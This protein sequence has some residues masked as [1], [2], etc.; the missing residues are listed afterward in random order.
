MGRVA[1]G[2]WSI[3]AAAEAAAVDGDHACSLE[4]ED[5]LEENVQSDPAV[6]RLR[7]SRC[8]MERAEL[9]SEPVGADPSGVGEVGERDAAVVGAAPPF[10][11]VLAFEGGDGVAGGRL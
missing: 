1:G 4:A 3:V 7:L 11:E 5:L 9:V 6:A 10:E 2:R 8:G